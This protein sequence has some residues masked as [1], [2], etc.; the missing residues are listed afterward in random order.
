MVY[1]PFADL[2]LTD[3]SEQMEIQYYAAFDLIK[4]ALPFLEKAQN[5]A[6]VNISSVMVDNV[7]PPHAM[8]PGSRS[9]CLDGAKATRKSAG[10]DR[11]LFRLLVDCLF[12]SRE[13]S[14]CTHLS[15]LLV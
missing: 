8:G 15:S 7:P 6:V 10:R 4:T 3:L 9:S 1:K 11:L 5:A 2:T 13:L 12:V 14:F